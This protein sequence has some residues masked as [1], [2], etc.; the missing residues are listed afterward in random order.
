ML[1][2]LEL[3]PA[4]VPPASVQSPQDHWPP[5]EAASEPLLRGGPGWHGSGQWLSEVALKK[6]EDQQRQERSTWKGSQASIRALE[7]R[8]GGGAGREEGA[9]HACVHVCACVCSV[10]ISGLPGQLA[11]LCCPAVWSS[12]GL[13]VPRGLCAAEAHT[14]PQKGPVDSPRRQ[15]WP[16]PAGRK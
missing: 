7:R 5:S 1:W 11:A 6:Q 9:V 15:E 16:C 3:L 13:E 2:V 14:C 8:A 12:M 4:S 10:Q